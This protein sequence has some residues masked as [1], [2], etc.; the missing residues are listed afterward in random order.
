MSIQITEKPITDLIPYAN[1][2][3]KHSDKQISLLA[4]SI[5]EFG[6]NNPILID[7]KNSVIAGH[8]RLEA[9]KKLGLSVVPTILLDHLSAAQ[10]KAFIL[11]D[12][13]IAIESTW[14]NDLL[15]LEL[16]ELKELDFDLN[17]TGF[18]LKEIDKITN[19]LKLDQE[20][21]EEEDFITLFSD[22]VSKPGDVWI[23]GDH[24]LICGDSTDPLIVEKLFNGAKPNL[25]VT[26]PPYGVEY[27][28]E[29][30]GKDLG[31]KKKGR[32]IGKVKNDDVAD[33]KDAYSLFTG[34]VAYVWHA[35][36]HTHTFASSLVDCGFKLI[37]QIVWSKNHFSISRGDYHWKH[38]PCWYVVRN[39]EK[40]N[41]QGARDQSTVWEIEANIPK[42]RSNNSENEKSGHST[43]KP[44]E[45]ML[46]PILN[47]SAINEFV[48]DPFGGSGTTMIACEKSKRKCLMIE[49]DP[50]YCDM[51]VKRWQKFAKS[52]A[53]LEETKEEFN[54]L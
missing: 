51:I 43:Q 25:M 29:W 3:R 31:E 42:A 24:R 36:A 14:D 35:A 15:K 9:A 2:A 11:A 5:Q 20:E 19:I 23:L 48:Y 21:D 54:A 13:R 27:D 10:K 30:R 45:C 26:D 40:H 39:G 37:N 12:N 16:D 17:L 47:N 53:F 52:N 7:S 18:D 49:L 8:A 1:N 44:V 22:A 38:E 46:R 32:A 33:W 41:W 6:F 50:R 34:N 4:S 28:P